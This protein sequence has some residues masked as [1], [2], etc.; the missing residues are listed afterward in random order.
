MMLQISRNAAQSDASNI[1]YMTKY[2]NSH[3][4]QTCLCNVDPLKPHFYIVKWS[5]QGNAIF[6][7]LALKFDCGSN[8]YPQSMF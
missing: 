2:D 3:I 7:K 8:E 4:M 6:L 1:I 5:L